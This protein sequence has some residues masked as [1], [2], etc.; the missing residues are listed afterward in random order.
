MIVS[1]KAL[2]RR[3]FALRRKGYTLAEI[4]AAVGMSIE[5]VRRTL[6]DAGKFPGRVPLRNHLSAEVA[7]AIFGLR[8]RGYSLREIGDAVGYSYETVRKVLR[9]GY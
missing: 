7:R 4:S 1:S 8:Q 9:E 2:R 5:I 3:I 6:L